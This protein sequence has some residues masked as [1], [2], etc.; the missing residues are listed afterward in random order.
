[1]ANAVK[2]FKTEKGKD[3][4]CFD[5][6]CYRFDKRLADDS[7]TWRCIQ[8]KAC[9]GRL[10][11]SDDLS[12]PVL[13]T[14][15]NSAIRHSDEEALLR[16]VRTKLRTRAAGEDTPIPAIYRQETRVLAP[17][18]TAAAVMPSFVRAKTSMYR[19]RIAQLP[20]LPQNRQSIQVPPLLQTTTSGQQ[21][22]QFSCPGNEFLI[23]AS[24]QDLSYLC[25]SDELAMDGT[26][27]TAPPLFTQLFTIH[28][29]VS[30][31][32][33]PMIYV[34]MAGKTSQMY[35]EVFRQ[36][37]TLCRQQVGRQLQP[38]RIM[39]DF[40]SGLIQAVSQQFPDASHK[41]CHFHYCQV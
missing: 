35:S 23:F 4:I 28:G 10:Q 17:N 33:V 20:V 26:F 9:N 29:Y 22:L 18:A 39:S 37:K 30:D 15:H 38:T 8:S 40:E 32:E 6:Y 36:L 41:G 24:Q 5:N 19:D 27:D 34:L 21:F 2:L 13:R 16:E 11:T 3:G 1:M 7:R 14:P 25:N 31:V 12:N